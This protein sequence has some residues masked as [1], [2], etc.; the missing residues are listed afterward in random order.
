[1]RSCSLRGSC[2]R[3]EARVRIARATVSRR[4]GDGETV[5]D[6]V[7]DV[8]DDARREERGGH[9]EAE[10]VHLDLALDIEALEPDA[11]LQV[12]LRHA[13]DGEGAG[14]AEHADVGR[15]EGEARARVLVAVTTRE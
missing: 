7:P 2:A 5:A 10:E 9:H 11:T 1:R 4:D 15:P 8:G 3:L 6:E 13:G 12:D 14:H